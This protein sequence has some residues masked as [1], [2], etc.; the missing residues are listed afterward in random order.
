M[1]TGR[2][3]EGAIY[4]HAMHAPEAVTRRAYAKVNLVLAV[5]S[6]IPAPAPFAGYH[7]IV[8]WM[9][10][11][12]LFD[13]VSVERLPDGMPSRHVIEWATDGPPPP[14]PSPIDWPVEKDL[15][16]R[17]HRLLERQVGRE[18]PVALRVMKRIPVGGGLG[19]GSADAAAALQALREIFKLP[20]S[21]PGLAAISTAL[22][23]DVGFFI[24]DHAPA[25]PA[26]VSN[27]GERVERVAA[28]KEAIVLIFPPFGCPTGAVYRAFDAA[29]QSEAA[30][31]FAD[32]AAAVHRLVESAAASGRIRTD[33]L[34]NDL[35]A[36]ACKVEPRLREAVDR[37]AA[38]L[39]AKVHVTGSGSTLIVLAEGDEQAATLA[40]RVPM[41]MPGIAAQA[42]RLL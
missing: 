10:S 7:P 13:E 18:L 15:A 16:V 2:P 35:T 37:L 39:N 41:V 31:S 26:I 25:P 11:V 4:H 30:A 19:G 3:S 17:A 9:S 6:P 5:D 22:G 23:S 42:S 27:L 29:N 38:E 24:D 21:T 40:A 32:R 14:R 28:V 20:I 34:F 1:R 36:P 8:S 12:D 33:E